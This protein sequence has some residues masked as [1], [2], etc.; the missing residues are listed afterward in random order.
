VQVVDVSDFMCDRRDCFP[1][2]GGALVLKD[3]HHLT[4][5]FAASLGPYVLRQVSALSRTWRG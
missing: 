1:V 2:V 4:R 3:L 5:V